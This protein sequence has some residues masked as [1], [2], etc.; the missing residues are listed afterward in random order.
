MKRNKKRRKLMKMNTKDK[1]VIE[2]DRTMK[3]INREK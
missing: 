3:A 2:K 1:R